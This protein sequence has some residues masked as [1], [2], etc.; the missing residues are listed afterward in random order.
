[1]PLSVSSGSSPAVTSS[2]NDRPVH[3]PRHLGVTYGR[4]RHCPGFCKVKDRWLDCVHE[5]SKDFCSHFVTDM[6]DHQRDGEAGDRVPKWKAQRYSRQ[7]DQCTERRDCIEPRV[8][9]ISS[10]R[11]R[12]DPLADPAFV[13]GNSLMCSQC[14]Y[15]SIYE[16]IVM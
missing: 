7:S 16:H 15:R 5:V 8:T 3:R 13:P 14:E 10:Q 9:G 11:R 4:D 1:M 6:A 12:L 2:R